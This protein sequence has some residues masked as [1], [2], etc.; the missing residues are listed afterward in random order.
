MN[1]AA[2]IA[3][4]LVR[5]AIKP[6]ALWLTDRQIGAAVYEITRLLEMR[7][8]IVGIVNSERVREVQLIERR[9]AIQKW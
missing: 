6:A 1:A 4:R 5:K 2:R 3:R 7:E 9:N 8:E